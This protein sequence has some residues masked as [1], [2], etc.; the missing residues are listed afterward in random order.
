MHYENRKE[1]DVNVIDSIAP[2]ETSG[3]AIKLDYASDHV[4]DFEQKIY[5]KPENASS[6][7]F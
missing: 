7:N 4:N 5:W 6:H 2:N 3:F 1:L